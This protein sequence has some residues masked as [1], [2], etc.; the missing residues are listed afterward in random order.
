MAKFFLFLAT[1][2]DLAIA[3]LLVGMSGFLFGGG[4]ESMHAGTLAL[5]GY[6][7]AIIGCL[8][9]PVVGFVFDKRGKIGLGQAVAWVPVAGAVTALGIPAPY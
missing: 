1:T 6:I 8:A 5:A 2:A 7:V 4:P 9:A 3:A